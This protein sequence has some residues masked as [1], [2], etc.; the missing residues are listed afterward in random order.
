M[1]QFTHQENGEDCGSLLIA[2]ERIK[3]VFSVQ[4]NAQYIVSR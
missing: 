2:F 4:N 1:P 3:Y